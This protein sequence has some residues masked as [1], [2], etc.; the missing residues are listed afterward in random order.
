MKKTENKE[1]DHKLIKL[2]GKPTIAYKGFQGTKV[3]GKLRCKDMLYEKALWYQLDTE[4]HVC[5]KGFHA[6]TCPSGVLR[7]Y[8][9][10]Q[11]RYGQ[12]E[13]KGI[14]SAE[15]RDDEA[16]LAVDNI[17][18]VKE[19]SLQEYAQVSQEHLRAVDDRNP[20][21]CGGTSVLKPEVAY[22]TSMWF[23]QVTESESIAW[24]QYEFS[25]AATFGDYSVAV[26]ESRSSV[27]VCRD[28]KSRAVALAYQSVAA[29]VD[30]WSVA[31]ARGDS[32]VAVTTKE[33]SRATVSGRYSIAAAMDGH[34]FAE[35]RNARSVAFCAERSGYVKVAANSVGVIFA[36][37]EYD[38]K[39]G[40]DEND[41]AYNCPHFCADEGARI[42][43]CLYERTGMGDSPYVEDATGQLVDC[44]VFEAGKD[45]EPNWWYEFSHGE[46][47]IDLLDTNHI[48]CFHHPDIPITAKDLKN[49][50]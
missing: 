45:F 36:H 40:D 22:S 35:V 29:A 33:C 9:P 3:E 16:K 41:K 17:K 31:E 46:L 42:V 5:K 48:V 18:V 21:W 8:P 12:V 47:K 11:S 50:V 24:S 26:A 23:T 6:C 43:I 13:L 38:V 4:P 14:G 25:V 32:S 10:N 19:Y 37:R 30:G 27:A 34:S 39:Q 28:N 49:G 44:K 15:P 20:C 2:T 1:E 7:F